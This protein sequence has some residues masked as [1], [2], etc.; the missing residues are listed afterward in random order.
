M[1]PENNPSVQPID[2]VWGKLGEWVFFDDFEKN[3]LIKE[4]EDAKTELAAARKKLEEKPVSRFKVS[5]E[6]VFT[7]KTSD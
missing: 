4:L 1:N 2:P 7:P 3:I 5:H 6:V